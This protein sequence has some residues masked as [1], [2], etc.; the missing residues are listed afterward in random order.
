MSGHDHQH[1]VETL[2]NTRLFT[3]MALNFIIT[4]T[5]VIGGLIS[6][7]LSLLSDA[8]HNFSDGLALIITYIALRLN[9][10]PSD[11]QYTFGLKRSEIIAAVIN[12]SSLIIISFFFAFN[13]INP[14]ISS[15]CLSM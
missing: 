4:I 9:L 1:K 14:R 5:E 2:S 12:A 15:N 6:G 7:S 10:R 13:L 8:L 11:A 3:A